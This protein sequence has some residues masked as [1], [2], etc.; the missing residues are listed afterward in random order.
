MNRIH[1]CVCMLSVSIFG[2]GCTLT[3][4]LNEKSVAIINSQ[5]QFEI[6]DIVVETLQQKTEGSIPLQI[7]M[8]GRM[9]WLRVWNKYCCSSR[10]RERWGSWFV[11]MFYEDGKLS[12]TPVAHA[13]AR[14]TKTLDDCHSIY[15]H[16]SVPK[17]GALASD[18]YVSVQ[19]DMGLRPCASEDEWDAEQRR[20][21]GRYS[22]VE[23]P[24]M[25]GEVRL[26]VKLFRNSSLKVASRSDDVLSLSAEQCDLASVRLFIDP[27]REPQW[28]D[29]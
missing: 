25:K 22:Y 12:Y 6:W 26:R 10:V 13:A 19:N 5:E 8:Q 21:I 27:T 15:A 7:E 11:W 3:P 14:P 1:A 20:E 17:R 4:E 29:F 9:K 23:K 18:S 16:I 28:E 24:G 2:L